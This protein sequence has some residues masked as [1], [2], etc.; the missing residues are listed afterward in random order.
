MNVLDKIKGGLIVSCQA[1]ED[2][3]LHSSFIMSRMAKAAMLGGAAGIRANS[4]QDISEIKKTVPLPVIGIIKT[5]YAESPVYITP[6]INEVNALAE[7]GCEIIAMD[8]TNRLRP[9]GETLADF[10]RKVR[11]NYPHQL[12]M[13]DCATYQE[14]MDA[15]V[16]GFDLIG[17]TLYGYTEETSQA[18]NDITPNYQMISELVKNSGKPVIA[19][20][21]IWTPEQL[22]LA[23]RCGIYAA[24]VGSAITRP[25][26]ITRRFVNAMKKD[27]V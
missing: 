21:N 19:E 25:M 24:V 7:C 15:A 14:G 17:T 23:V 1:L 20:G 5:V 13:A 8:A 26:L 16:M 11:E 3:P 27:E 2:E 18:R 9:G 10:F 12:F 4:A 22:R 6:T